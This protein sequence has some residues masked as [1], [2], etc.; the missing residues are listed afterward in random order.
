MRN[1]LT[2]SV[3]VLAF[4]VFMAQQANAFILV[5]SAIPGSPAQHGPTTSQKALLV[6]IAFLIHPVEGFF[7]LLDDNAN[8]Y[9]Q[10]AAKFMDAGAPKTEAEDLAIL[11]INSAKNAGAQSVVIPADEIEAAAPTFSQS[12]GFSSF[13]RTAQ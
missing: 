10:L 3:F 6:G 1:F 11:V 5:M 4:S 13:M 7:A 2:K 8:A 12:E 9:E